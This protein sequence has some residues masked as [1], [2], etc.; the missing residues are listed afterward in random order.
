MRA[1]VFV[2]LEK[3]RVRQNGSLPDIRF[4]VVDVDDL[5]LFFD[6][7]GKEHAV[8]VR[9]FGLKLMDA[10]DV[11]LSIVAQDEVMAEE[12]KKHISEENEHVHQMLRDNVEGPLHDT[13]E[14]HRGEK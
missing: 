13:W 4:I 10:A 8:N 2:N 1:S 12:L 6:G 14:E 3:V 11:L 9:A 7:Y 5:S